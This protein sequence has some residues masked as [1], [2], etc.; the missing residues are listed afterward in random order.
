M[1]DSINSNFCSIILYFAILTLSAL[2]IAICLSLFI[3]NISYD[4]TDSPDEAEPEVFEPGESST[5]KKSRQHLGTTACSYEPP[6]KRSNLNS[7]QCTTRGD[8]MS[9]VLRENF[10]ESPGK[11]VSRVDVMNTLKTE[12]KNLTTRAVKETFKS[13][14]V[15]KHKDQY[16]NIRRSVSFHSTSTDSTSSFNSFPDSNI[17]HLQQQVKVHKQKAKE[18]METIITSVNDSYIKTL[19]F[20][21]DKEMMDCVSSL[22][23]SIDIL[24]KTEIEFL[25]K[26]SDHM[27]ASET[28]LLIE[29]FNKL[30]TIVNLGIRTGKNFADAEITSDVFKNFKLDFQRDC[31]HLTDLIQALF[32]GDNERKEKGA[33]H[34]LGLLASLRNKQC[35][36]DITLLFTILLVSYGAGC[37]MVNMLNKVGLTIHWDTLMNF[38]EEQ[39]KKKQ[40][41]ITS[42]TPAGLPLLLL[43]DNINISRGNKRHYRLFQKYGEHMWNF[44]GRG[45][46]VPRLD[47]IEHLFQCKETVLESQHD[48]TDFTFQNIC[49]ENNKEH[50]Q[51]WQSHRDE[52]LSKLMKDGLSLRTNSHKNL[53]DM[54]GMQQM[55]I[56]QGLCNER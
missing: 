53:E 48:V 46:L 14:N 28:N 37:R 11:V 49:I 45:L 38:F 27:S 10:V 50:L 4:F 51:I 40:D 19:V 33:M 31:L 12:N 34:A 20:M 29:E 13:V 25:M 15:E 3:F 32:P 41:F 6:V 55:L 39:L 16:K 5:P 56:H 36:N 2:L 42:Q 52:Y 30:S 7:I 1:K 23:E 43:M 47:K 26:H 44:T 9:A 24:Y 21:Y 17:N 22:T 54:S 18:I 35:R 8:E